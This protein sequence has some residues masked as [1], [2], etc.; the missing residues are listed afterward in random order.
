VEA[1]RRAGIENVS[2]D[3]IFGLP[4]SLGRSWDDD[5]SRVLEMDVLHVSLYGLTVETGTPLGRAVREGR[6]TPVDEEQ[7]AREFE[8]AAEVLT[9]AGYEH[10]E[11]SNFAR[12][13]SRSRHNAV[14]WEGGAWLGLGNGAHSYAPPVRRWN[15][16][17]W[18]EYRDALAAG[19]SPEAERETVDASA[20]RLEQIW[21]GLR[22]AEGIAPP[23]PGS[24]A[25]TLVS[26]WVAQG[27][28]TDDGASVT[29][30]TAGWLVLDRLAVELDAR[31]GAFDLR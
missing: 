1:A 29:L 13:G 4:A 15:T 27:L 14:Y 7:Y 18:E 26:E 2:V 19:G 22:T 6:V 3:L 23:R 16:R 12:P 20:H 9:D 11:V 31:D 24:P 17:E 21:L 10:Y 30:T 5:L 8:R 25:A 28:A